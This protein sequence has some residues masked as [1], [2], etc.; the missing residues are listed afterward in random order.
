MALQW[1]AVR[2]KPDGTEESRVTL[3]FQERA[4]SVEQ[5]IVNLAG[6]SGLL[7]VGTNMGGVDLAH[8]FDPDVAP[9]EPSGG[10]LYVTRL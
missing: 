2:I 4:T 8:P 1:T 9:Y 5:R 7:L 3:P 6:L 10:T